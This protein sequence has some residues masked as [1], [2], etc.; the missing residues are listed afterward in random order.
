MELSSQ[1]KINGGIL[2]YNSRSP[3]SLSFVFSFTVISLH[4]LKCFHFNLLNDLSLKWLK[5]VKDGERITHTWLH[6]PGSGTEILPNHG[7]VPQK[8]FPQN[9]S[10][11]LSQTIDKKFLCLYSRK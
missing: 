8:L 7:S 4:K 10:H 3:G 11:F 6:G 9:L 2:I 1:P 5:N